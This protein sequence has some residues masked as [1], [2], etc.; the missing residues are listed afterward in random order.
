M[1]EIY[2]IY[3]TLLSMI[4]L[5]SSVTD[6]DLFRK[7]STYLAHVIC[8]DYIYCTHLLHRSPWYLVNMACTR[9]K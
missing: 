6:E 8:S 2:D 5:S 4:G 3:H 9:Y 1:Y 7:V